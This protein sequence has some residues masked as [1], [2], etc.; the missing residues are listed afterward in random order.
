MASNT[1]HLRNLPIFVVNPASSRRKASRNHLFPADWSI[2][3][4]PPVFQNVCSSLVE[5]L[6]SL[7]LRDPNQ[8]RSS[9][10]GTLQ[11]RS[12][13]LWV[14]IPILVPSV[15][16]VG[17]A[18]FAQRLSQLL[19]APFFYAPSHQ[20]ELNSLQHTSYLREHSTATSQFLVQ[21]CGLGDY[22]RY[23]YKPE[24]ASSGSATIPPNPSVSHILQRCAPH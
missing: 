1:E 20:A 3:P 23:S 24:T 14:V 11:Y 18:L 19:Y 17:T 2:S 10:K 5:V 16:R 6:S 13:N 8:A 9:G 15:P 4:V 7:A 22:S 21:R 12:P